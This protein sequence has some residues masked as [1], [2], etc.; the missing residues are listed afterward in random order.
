MDDNAKLELL[1]ELIQINT[2]NGHEQP[3]AEYLKQVLTTHGI[4]ARL[5]EQAPHRADLVAE[6]GQQPGPVL[7]LAGHLDTVDV[8][9]LTKWQTEPFGGQVK[10]GQIY[11]RGSVDMKGGL[12][13]MIT[14]LIELKE[15]GLPKHGQVRLLATIDEEGAGQGAL[16]LTR[17]GLVD[18]ASALIIGEA[19]NNQLKYAH[20]GSLDYRVKAYGK[21]AHSSR[22]LNGINAVANLARFMDAER[23]AF[24]DILPN[25]ALGELTH[26]I[27]VFH[28]GRQVKTIPDYAYLEGNVRT[29][30]ECDNTETAHRLQKIVDQLNQQLAGRLVFE[31]MA[32]LVP[33]TTDPRD[34]FITLTQR[35]FAR[36]TGQ[37]LPLGIS[38][39][40]TD[41]SRFALAKR[42][43][44]IIILG[45]GQ[46][47]MAHQT[48]EALSVNEYLL[49]DRIYYQI[50][51]DFL[52]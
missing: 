17:R 21:T 11:G 43:F 15:A 44:P 22:P 14:A 26:N 24:D 35:A 16:E 50:A 29:I 48:D 6:I 42:Q 49:A 19:T 9:D 25:S 38:H 51:S 52:G 13:A 8:G 34:S 40:A 39:S 47:Q 46:E 23:S 28:G 41:A 31:V 18:D 3:A 30:P 2:V 1:M 20:S 36:V 5:I 37:K 7:V 12:A 27:T 45:P 33:V 4:E 32:N 10:D